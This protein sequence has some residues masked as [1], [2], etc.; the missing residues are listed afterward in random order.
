M[1][2]LP[3]ASCTGVQAYREFMSVNDDL[4]NWIPVA[5]TL[6]TDQQPARLTEFD[7]LFRDCVI[8]VDRAGPMFLR[9][10]LEGGDEVTARV[11]DLTARETQCC[12]FFTFE[13]SPAAH[14]LRLHMQVPHEQVAVLD[15]FAA[16]AERLAT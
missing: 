15:A 2:F 12:S 5:C 6:P 11:Q 13:L 9:L 8:E 3:L 14:G 4:P 1:H 7:A 10:T 16:R